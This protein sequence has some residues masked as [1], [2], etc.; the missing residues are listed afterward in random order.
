MTV[1]DW[2]E[3]LEQLDRDELALLKQY[4]GDLLGGDNKA[5]DDSLP[6]NG[7]GDGGKGW[8]E[9]KTINGHRYRYLRWYD[10]DV[11]RSKYLGKAAEGE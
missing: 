8:V 3:R 2:Q 5:D 4:I 6:P 1:D 9:I 11:K 7:T 10:G